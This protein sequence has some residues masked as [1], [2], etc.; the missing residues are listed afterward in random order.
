[1]QSLATISHLSFPR[2]TIRK[3]IKERDQV[4][5]ARASASAGALTRGTER[6]E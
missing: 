2:Y 3:R 1:M 5:R 4:T 6:H